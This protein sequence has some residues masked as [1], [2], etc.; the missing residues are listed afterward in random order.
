[1]QAQSSHDFL[2]K[3]I[4]NIPNDTSGTEHSSFDDNSHDIVIE[5]HLVATTTIDAGESQSLLVDNC[6]QIQPETENSK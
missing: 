4:R 1:M 2:K 3:I 5:K 6:R